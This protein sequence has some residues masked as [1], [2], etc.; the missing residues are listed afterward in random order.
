MVVHNEKV[1]LMGRNMASEMF[2]LDMF[3]AVTA[4]RE[5]SHAL[6]P[7]R[8]VYGLCVAQLDGKVCIAAS[9]WSVMPQ[10]YIYFWVYPNLAQ[11]PYYTYTDNYGEIS[12]IGFAQGRLFVQNMNKIQEFDTS[13]K[14]IKPTGHEIA[15]GQPIFLPAIDLRIAEGRELGNLRFF[16]NY[17]TDEGDLLRCFSYHGQL[18]WC[19]VIRIGKRVQPD[20]SKA[21][22]QVNIDRPAYN[23][24]D[25]QCR[26]R[27]TITARLPDG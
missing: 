5:I 17:R 24:T 18:L 9:F 8:R 6:N 22:Q 11:E 4:E 21:R 20:I 16:L 7:D 3:N 23:K 2:T 14:P 10:V 26:T 1:I 15:T 19:K 25:K 13:S 27:T 12:K